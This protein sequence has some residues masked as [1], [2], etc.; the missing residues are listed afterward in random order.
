MILDN[1]KEWATDIYNNM[2]EIQIL[3]EKSQSQGVHTEWL[4]LCEVV[5]NANKCI[6]TEQV[7]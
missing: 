5:E 3:S 1:K 4:H 7:I 6:V 2:D